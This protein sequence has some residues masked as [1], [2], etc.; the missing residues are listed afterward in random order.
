MELIGG[1][2]L[3]EVVAESRQDSQKVAQI[4]AEVSKTV[5]FAHQNGIIHRDLKPANVLIDAEENAFVVDFG[6]VGSFQLT[7]QGEPDP[8]IVGTRGYMAPEILSSACRPVDGKVDI[9]AIGVMLHE[10]L[11]G[12]RPLGVD[13]QRN[14]TTTIW[15]DFI[16]R[17]LAKIGMR[18][19]EQDPADR[20][21][22][23]ELATALEAFVCGT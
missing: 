10:L 14:G 19:L 8:M 22:A 18:C 11:T 6:L 17:Q 15:P 13:E 1:R 12:E 20:Y 9:Y 4:L 23:H 3:R 16:P 5:A 21:D 2:S 7:R